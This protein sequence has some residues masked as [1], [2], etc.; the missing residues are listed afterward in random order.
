LG[1]ARFEYRFVGPIAPETA[2]LVLQLQGKATFESK[3]AESQLPESYAWGDVFMLPTVED[4]YAIVLAQAA[5]AGLPVLTTCNSAGDDL[6]VN[7]RNG[8]VLPIR[9]PTAFVQRLQWADR[10]RAALAEMVSNSHSRLEVRDASDM[11]AELV[12]VCTEYLR[13]R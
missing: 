13:N 3:Q 1:T 7:G 9:N 5:A 10:H 11:A 6:I 4:G 8:W 2:H 12:D